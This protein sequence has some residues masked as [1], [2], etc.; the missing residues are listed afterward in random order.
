MDFEECGSFFSDGDAKTAKVIFQLSQDGKDLGPYVANVKAPAGA[1]LQES[2]FMEVSPPEPLGHQGPRPEVP[3]GKYAQAVVTYMTRMLWQLEDDP[4]DPLAAFR[5]PW[6]AE[7]ESDGDG[8]G[9]W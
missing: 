3:H 4:T 7:F 8:Q 6:T 9:G 5:Y 1:G 2:A